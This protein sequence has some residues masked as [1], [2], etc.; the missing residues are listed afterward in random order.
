MTKWFA[1]SEDGRW[2]E[3]NSS[4]YWVL[5]A[6]LSTAEWGYAIP[7]IPLAPRFVLKHKRTDTEFYCL[8]YLGADTPITDGITGP[9]VAEVPCLTCA[10]L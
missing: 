2:A 6:G 8:R 4:L 5:I 1:T 3:D 10:L 9:Y 7:C